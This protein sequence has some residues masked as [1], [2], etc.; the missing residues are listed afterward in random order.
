[1]RVLAIDVNQKTA[2]TELNDMTRSTTSPTIPP[3]RRF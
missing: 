2:M 1:M 3:L